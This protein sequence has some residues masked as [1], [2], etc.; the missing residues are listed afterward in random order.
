MSLSSLLRVESCSTEN[1]ELRKKVE[2]LEN[3]NRWVWPQEDGE[4]SWTRAGGK[5]E[6]TENGACLDT[7]V[8][9]QCLPGLLHGLPTYTQV[10]TQ[11]HM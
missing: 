8:A 3:T 6:S 11:I 4:G 1:L 7:Q 10:Y 2:V 5:G 9:G